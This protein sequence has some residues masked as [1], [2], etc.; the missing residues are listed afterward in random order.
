MARPT[1]GSEIQP[2][3]TLRKLRNRTQFPAWPTLT[4]MTKGASNDR[5]GASALAG[6]TKIAKPN[7][8]SGL[9]DSDR[10]D[11]KCVQRSVEVIGSNRIFQS[12]RRNNDMRKSEI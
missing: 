1:I 9:V 4:E 8:I 11:E 3:P 5:S 10:N 7:P 2:R 12:G 6:D